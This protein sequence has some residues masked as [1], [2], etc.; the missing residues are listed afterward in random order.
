MGYGSNYTF[1]Y[2]KIYLASSFGS[3]N[4]DKRKNSEKAAKILRDNNYEVYCPWEYQIPHAWDYSNNEWGL[5]VFT[6]D[7]YAL[8]HSDAVVMLSYGRLATASGTNWEAGYAYG[9]GKKVIVVEMEEPVAMSV[10]VSNGCYARIKGLEKLEK[11][12]IENPS[13]TNRNKTDTWQE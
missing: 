13:M 9:I 7:V 2:M 5:M 11:Y 12:L 1:I 3:K 8:D 6:N 10:M 4:S